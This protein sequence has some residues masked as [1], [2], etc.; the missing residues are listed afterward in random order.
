[1]REGLVFRDNPSGDE[2]QLQAFTLTTQI[3]RYN[4]TRLTGSQWLSGEQDVWFANDSG[5]RKTF[6]LDATY[7]SDS[8]Q[9]ITHAPEGTK[10]LEIWVNTGSDSSPVWAKQSVA[11]GSEAGTKPLGTLPGEVD[12]HW[13]PLDK[14][15]KFRVTPRVGDPAFRVRGRFTS[16]SIYYVPDRASIG[17]L[18]RTL[19]HY[20]NDPNVLYH[21]FG[22]LTTLA[23]LRENTDQYQVSFTSLEEVKVGQVVSVSHSRY[24]IDSDG[25]GN[26]EPMRNV[27]VF[28]KK[29]GIRMLDAS[30]EEYEVSGNVVDVDLYKPPGLRIRS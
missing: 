23:Q 18:N 4:N 25:D 20:I 1:M 19:D 7:N 13:Y 3:A 21:D 6:P 2:V 27:D 17:R 11:F 15:V 28:V 29:V 24:G 10:Y 8:E 5:T 14:Q 16:S 9:V 26:E 30:T 22:Y 12:V